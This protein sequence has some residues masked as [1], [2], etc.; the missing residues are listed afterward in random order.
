MIQCLHKKVEFEFENNFKAQER[1][2][3]LTHSQSHFNAEV[4]GICMQIYIH[5]FLFNIKIILK[6]F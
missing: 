5:F 1:D 4:H 2:F 3:F 6:S